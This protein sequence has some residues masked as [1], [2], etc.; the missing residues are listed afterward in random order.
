MS[1]YH[2]I[3]IHGLE[4]SNQGIKATLLR[5]L[6]PGIL[7]PNFSGILSERMSQLESHLKDQRDWT[8]IGSSLG[9]LMAAMYACQ[10]P[11]GVKKLLLLAPALIWPEFADNLPAPVDMPVTIIHGSR[12]ELVPLQ[13]TRNLAE[14]VFRNLTFQEVDDDHGLY[15]TVHQLDWHELLGI[16][17]EG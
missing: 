3:F 12:D 15:K 6:F 5:R 9:G 7:A 14:Q 16:P 1:K 13:A 17:A 10:V 4:G 2:L 8:I 11:Q